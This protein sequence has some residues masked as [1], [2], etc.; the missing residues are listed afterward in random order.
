M[1]R[2]KSL[3]LRPPTG[4]MSLIGRRAKTRKISLGGEPSKNQ[5]IIASAPAETSLLP[6][7]RGKGII[8]SALTFDAL[9]FF[10][11]IS[12][13]CHFSQKTEP[14]VST[15]A[16]ELSCCYCTSAISVNSPFSL[17]INISST[18]SNPI[19]GHRRIPQRLYSWLL[20]KSKSSKSKFESK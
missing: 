12:K 13:A 4:M 6:F 7:F 15:S 18:Y 8:P 2:P 17:L 9:C 14:V 1:F 10:L 5:N 11:Q 3:S 20:Q 19:H 16:R